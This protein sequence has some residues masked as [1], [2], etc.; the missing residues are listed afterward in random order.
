[1]LSNDTISRV[2]W[3]KGLPFQATS[4]WNGLVIL[5]A[6]PFYAGVTFRR[7]KKGECGASECSLLARDFW[8]LR[9]G[10]VVIVPSVK[11]TYWVD[12]HEK[13]HRDLPPF[14]VK[15]PDFNERGN[16]NNGM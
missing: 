2:R 1:M 5:D 7:N 15:H 4:C 11:L 12:A 8:D 14:P 9:H 16:K 6:R 13:V 3:E 10:R